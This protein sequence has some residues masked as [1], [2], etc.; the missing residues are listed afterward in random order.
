LLPFRFSLSISPIFHSVSAELK[1]SKSFSGQLREIQTAAMTQ[2]LNA[3]VENRVESENKLL[4]R[5]IAFEG[6][7]GAGKSTLCSKFKQVHPDK[8]SL[9]KEMGNEKFLQLFYSNPAKYGFAYQ[10]GML[11]TRRFQ[12]S[13]AQ[14]DSKHGRIPPKQFY[15]WDRSMVGD[16]IFALWNHLL[17]SISQQEMLVYEDGIPNFISLDLLHCY[18]DPSLFLRVRRLDEGCQVHPLPC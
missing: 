10:W 12:L 14:H 5:V 17:G 11:K 16:Y 13:L 7:I 8:C 1:P 18:P 3:L 4:N 9:Y 2:A 6:N 15:F